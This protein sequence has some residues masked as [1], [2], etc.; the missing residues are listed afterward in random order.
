MNS[1]TPRLYPPGFV[2]QVRDQIARV[3]ETNSANE[4]PA[5]CR[6][7]GIGEGE[8]SEA[9]SGKFKYVVRRLLELPNDRVMRI[10]R[11][12]AQDEG[13][14]DLLRLLEAIDRKPATTAS[15]GVRPVRRTYYSERNRMG[16]TGGRLDLLTII[17]LFK[18]EYK[19]LEQAGYFTEAFGFWCVDLEQ[20]DG[21]VGSDVEAHITYS[22]GRSGL[23]PIESAYANYSE[24]DLFSLIEYLFDHVSKPV[25]GT[26]HT[27][28]GCGM[29]WETF[30]K[31]AG[32]AEFLGS[33]NRL[34][35]R[36]GDGWELT[37][38]GE[39]MGRAPAGTE[40]LLGADLPH[41]DDNISGRVE[42]AIA[43]FRLRHA[44]KDDRRDA[45]RDLADVL[46]YLRPAA[47]SVLD[48]KD[49]NDLFNIA[50]NFG[51]RHHNSSQK[52]SYDTSIWLSWMFY[53]YL[54][55]IHAVVRLIEKADQKAA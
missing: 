12:V 38:T 30:D 23:W 28:Q 21:L 9:F 17:K 26:M 10:A 43:K 37:T 1:N 55:T 42:S 33:M 29:H 25:S 53:F 16:P 35:E 3:I 18:S 7:Y 24:D 6:R 46:E 54:A 49:E 47:K 44:T 22:V 5:I 14:Q 11:D 15:R 48:K 36:Y 41:S 52:T 32:Q 31:S 45:V 50:N 27:Y 20:V 13:D 8:V 34:L 39:I 51:I 4:V 40:V 2:K 19:R